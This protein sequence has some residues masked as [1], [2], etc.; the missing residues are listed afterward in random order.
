MAEIEREII[1]KTNKQC[2]TGFPTLYPCPNNCSLPFEGVT[3]EQLVVTDLLGSSL[4][5]FSKQKPL[6]IA[7]VYN[8]GI[9]LVSNLI[10]NNAVRIQLQRIRDLHN[11]GIVHGDIKP[12]NILIGRT[13]TPST[14]TTTMTKSRLISGPSSHHSDINLISGLLSS[15]GLTSSHSSST[16][17]KV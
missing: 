10:G 16:S 15:S 6:T 2:F 17:S 13:K 9:Q 8:V 1:G 7:Q 14:H 11:I 12:C 3:H 4:S 5:W